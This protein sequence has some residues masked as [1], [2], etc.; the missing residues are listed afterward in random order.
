MGAPSGGSFL[1]AA[2]QLSSTS[3]APA[4]RSRERAPSPS[5]PLFSQVDLLSDGDDGHSGG[6]GDGDGDPSRLFAAAPEG[7]SGE[8]AV[9]YGHGGAVL[10]PS[11]A[12]RPLAA[13]PAPSS[14]SATVIAAVRTVQQG[15]Q[16][17]LLSV[18]VYGS[19][20]DG[21][22]FGNSVEAPPVT[23]HAGVGGGGHLVWVSQSSPGRGHVLAAAVTGAES[24]PN[25]SPIASLFHCPFALSVGWDGGAALVIFGA[26][27]EE[28]R[29]AWLAGVLALRSITPL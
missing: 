7:D 25:L 23:V 15:G 8:E 6:G 11:R 28:E 13:L 21:R 2:P 14:P 4:R 27:S 16:L 5:A 20:A 10:S 1:D 12:T 26:Q 3:P 19:P 22:S 29:F 24:M 18:A 17:A 9:V